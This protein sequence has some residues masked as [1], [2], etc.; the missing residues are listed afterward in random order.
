MEATPGGPE[1]LPLLTAPLG[2]SATHIIILGNPTSADAQFS[3]SSSDP[4][5]FTV[6]P[7]NLTVPPQGSA[8]VLL[9]Y[10]PSSLGAEETATVTVTSETAGNVEYLC[11]GQVRTGRTWTLERSVTVPLCVYCLESQLKLII[12]T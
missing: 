7:E 2:R 9:E 12:M 8:E 1:Q 11:R 4:T 10:R 3:C 6:K 5:R